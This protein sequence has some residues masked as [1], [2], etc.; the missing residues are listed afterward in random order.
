M[1]LSLF[2]V[3]CA[4]VVVF[5]GLCVVGCYALLL[6][7]ATCWCSVVCRWCVVVVVRCFV[8]RP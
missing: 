3:C 5:R 8:G 4:F 1:S 6:V 2:G 7:V